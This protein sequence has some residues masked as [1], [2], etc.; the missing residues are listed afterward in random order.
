MLYAPLLVI[1]S[2][3]RWAVLGV[4]AAALVRGGRKSPLALAWLGLLDLQ[5]VIGIALYGWLSP[6]TSA[7]FADFRG[8]MKDSVLRFWAVEH[9]FAMLLAVIVAHVGR[10]LSKRA[11]DDAR[12]ARIMQITIALSLLCIVAGMPWSV[13][14]YGRPLFRV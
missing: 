4:G 6:M 3:L 13:T 7:A 5:L 11:D 9:A 1:H 12:A 10:V 14:K 8:A 2:W